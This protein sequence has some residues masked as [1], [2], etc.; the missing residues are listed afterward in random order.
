[1]QPPFTALVLVSLHLSSF[2]NCKPVEWNLPRRH[3]MT[4]KGSQKRPLHRQNVSDSGDLLLN[5]NLGGQLRRL[6]KHESLVMLQM[7]KD[8]TDFVS[9]FDLRKRRFLCVDFDG[10]LFNSL[11]VS[12]EECLFQY[13]EDPLDGFYSSWPAGLVLS[14]QDSEKTGNVVTENHK[15][16]KRSSALL[17]HFILPRIHRTKRSGQVSDPSDPLENQRQPRRNGEQK[18]DLHQ[19]KSDKEQPGAVSKETITSCDDPLQ[20]LHSNGPISPI[21]TNIEDRTEKD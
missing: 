5:G 17:A 12:K 13:Q 7:K 15:S 21:K 4:T 1:M 2:V 18:P 6:I 3:R 11:I 20:V 8:S 16:L 19:G 10:E 14:L 9:I